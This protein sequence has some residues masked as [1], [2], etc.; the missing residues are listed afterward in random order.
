MYKKLVKYFLFIILPMNLLFAQETA[1]NKDYTDN[2]ISANETE[3]RVHQNSINNGLN[4]SNDKIKTTDNRY[5]LNINK[6]VRKSFIDNFFR[7]RSS[8]S[9][10]QK[11]EKNLVTSFSQN[12][13]MGGLSGGCALISF[14]PKLN[15]E[16]VEFISI[17]AN[18]NV[19]YLIPIKNINENLQLLFFQSAYILGIDNFINLLP[20]THSITQS[21][22]GFI[23][24]N[25]ITSLV[26]RV[27]DNNSKNKAIPITSYNYS[28]TIRL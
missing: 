6:G 2:N 22:A 27:I 8:G 9:S 25:F 11:P 4:S 1:T 18:Q 17:S 26:S 15:L 21:I 14:T 24:K 3:F 28:I 10:H 5:Y 19:R 7:S 23:A 12:I 20:K 16:P 13:E